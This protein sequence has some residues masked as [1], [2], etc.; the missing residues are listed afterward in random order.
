MVSEKYIVLRW[1]IDHPEE[2][3]N[4]KDSVYSG[5]CT[6]LYYSNFFRSFMR[7]KDG[8]F[9]VDVPLNR[10]ASLYGMGLLSDSDRS[11]MPF[12]HEDMDE[13]GVKRGYID[14]GLF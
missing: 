7:E 12:S 2:K 3:V 6:V 4:L 5:D 11:F 14:Y 9:V 10:C 8:K 1:M 13:I